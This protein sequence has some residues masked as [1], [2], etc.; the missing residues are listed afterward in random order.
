MTVEVCYYSQ[1]AVG[2]YFA[3][4]QVFPLSHGRCPL[5]YSHF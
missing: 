3:N 1:L 5:W 2:Q 4:N